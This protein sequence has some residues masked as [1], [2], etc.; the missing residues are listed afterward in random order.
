[1]DQHKAAVMPTLWIVIV[2]LVFAVAADFGAKPALGDGWRGDRVMR[3]NR[4]AKADRCPPY[5]KCNGPVSTR[6]SGCD[7][8]YP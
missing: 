1:M 5:W 4:K 8:C 7:V 2:S 6:A 3:V